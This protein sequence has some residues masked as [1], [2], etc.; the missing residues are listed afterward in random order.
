MLR[1]FSLILNTNILLLVEIHIF[2]CLSFSILGISSFMSL[3][4]FIFIFESLS[5]KFT[6]LLVPTHK[7]LFSPFSK[8]VIY[9]LVNEFESFS[10]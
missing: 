6:P 5:I 2:P 10:L 7:V 3:F 1:F 4:L 9:E 8:H